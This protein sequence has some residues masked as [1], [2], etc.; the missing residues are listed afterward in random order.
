MYFLLEEVGK[1]ISRIP[2]QTKIVRIYIDGPYHISSL[3]KR[4][5]RWLICDDFPS[6]CAWICVWSLIDKD[7]ELANLP[8]CNLYSRVKSNVANWQP[9][10]PQKQP[11]EILR[12][13]KYIYPVHYRGRINKKRFSY[14][15][16]R[17]LHLKIMLSIYWITFFFFTFLSEKLWKR[18]Q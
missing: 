11:I 8:S 14:K 9:S 13:R 17:F 16:L 12:W 5:S 2:I 1:S 15:K 10:R 18:Q 3:K 6:S 4:L 7:R